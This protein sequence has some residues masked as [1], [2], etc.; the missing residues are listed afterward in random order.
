[1]HAQAYLAVE[2]A[3]VSIHLQLLDVHIELLREHSGDLVQHAHV[4]DAID[5][6]GC[7][8]EEFLVRIPIGRQDVVAVAGFQF[9]R[10]LALTLVDGDVGLPVKVSQHIISWYD[11]N[12]QI[13]DEGGRISYYLDELK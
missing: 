6:D 11:A 13:G 8:E 3:V 4:V 9:G 5:V 2:D 1:M 7:R 12:V 10:Y